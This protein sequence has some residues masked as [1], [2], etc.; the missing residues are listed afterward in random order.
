MREKTVTSTHIVHARTHSF[1]TH[2]R[3][4]AR[5]AQFICPPIVFFAHASTQARKHAH[6]HTHARMHAHTAITTVETTIA[7][8]QVVE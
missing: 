7:T 6:T 5:T 4:H 2:A 8:R 3:T 1:S